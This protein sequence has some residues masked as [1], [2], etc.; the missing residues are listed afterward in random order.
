MHFDGLFVWFACGGVPGGEVRCS[1]LLIPLADTTGFVC[2]LRFEG[3]AVCGGNSR[4]EVSE[5]VKEVQHSYERA[6]DDR[7][8]GPISVCLCSRGRIIDCSHSPPRR[9]VIGRDLV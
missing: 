6:T 1:A 5:G 2:M 9:C 7:V 3:E 8:I 4:V